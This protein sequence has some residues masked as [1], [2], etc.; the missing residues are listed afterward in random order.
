MSFIYRGDIRLRFSCLNILSAELFKLPVFQL[1]FLHVV[2]LPPLEGTLLS[3]AIVMVAYSK[4]PIVVLDQKYSSPLRQLETISEP[5]R[6]VATMINFLMC[7]HRFFSLAQPS[8]HYIGW[9]TV[10]RLI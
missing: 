1:L 8:W 5:K 4:A 3:L 9:Q 10:N 2:G 6:N 7:I